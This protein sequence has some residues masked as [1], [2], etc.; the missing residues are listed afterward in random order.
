MGRRQSDHSVE[1][2]KPDKVKEDYKAMAT[3][4]EDDKSRKQSRQAPIDDHMK[5]K[6][7]HTL[8]IEDAH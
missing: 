8:R 1:P 7:R 5:L 6:K 3:F 2:V 4:K